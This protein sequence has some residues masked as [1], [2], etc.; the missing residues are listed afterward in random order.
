MKMSNGEAYAIIKNIKKKTQFDYSYKMAAIRHVAD[1]P[2]LNGVTKE[3]L[4]NAIKFLLGDNM[5]A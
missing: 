1:M 4:R 5:E 3:D 2:T